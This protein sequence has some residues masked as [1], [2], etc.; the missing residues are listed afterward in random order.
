MA[1]AGQGGGAASGPAFPN[2]TPPAPPVYPQQQ[3]PNDSIFYSIDVECVATGIKHNARSVGQISLVVRANLSS[4]SSWMKG[5]SPQGSSL[6]VGVSVAHQTK[7]PPSVCA[8]TLGCDYS[9]PV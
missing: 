8:L 9:G 6:T 3:L 2:P 1:S 4:T 7:F 5:P